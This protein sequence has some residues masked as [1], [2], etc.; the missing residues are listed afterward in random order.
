MSFKNHKLKFYENKILDIETGFEVMMSWEKNLMKEHAKIA[1]HNQGDVLEIGFGMGISA[2]EIQKLK[3]KSHTIV[4][5]HPQI[6]EKLY[7]WAKEKEN[8]II[9][10]G[11]WL[12]KIHQL[13][14]YDGILFDP[15]LD[16]DCMKILDHSSNLIKPNGK[17]TFWNYLSKPENIYNFN[18]TY[19][20]IA[21]D[22]P[23]NTYFNHKKYYLPTVQF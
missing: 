18:A 2:T 7:E 19:K 1:C 6:L 12:K 10:E 20:E 9:V 4:E 22:P 23:R 8:V 5:P 3:P 17:I 15:H 16:D 21:V 11:E 13:K 14:K